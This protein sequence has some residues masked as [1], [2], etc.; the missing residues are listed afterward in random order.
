VDKMTP[1][2]GW[3]GTTGGL[4]YLD[5][6]A[7]VFRR[8]SDDHVAELE[9]VSSAPW[10]GP[11]QFHRW[12]LAEET[13]LFQRFDIGIMPLPSTDYTRAKAGFKLLQYMSAGL[14]VVA[15]PLGVNRELID[16]SGGGVLADSPREWDDALRTLASDPQLRSRL[17]RAGR[18]FVER[19]ADVEAKGDLLANLLHG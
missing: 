4:S 10:R 19:Y 6:L 12:T 18:S 14:P 9:V 7:D 5:P 13:S 16:Q 3:A 15:S 17:G 2:V 8:L 1:V 11:A